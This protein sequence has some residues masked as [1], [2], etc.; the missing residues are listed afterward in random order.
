[1]NPD[2]RTLKDG[3]IAAASSSYYETLRPLD[4]SV[5]PVASST[6]P[7]STLRQTDSASVRVLNVAP[8]ALLEI[9]LPADHLELFV[10]ALTPARLAYPISQGDA[11]GEYRS[12]RACTQR[13][14]CI[15]SV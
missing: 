1:M 7:S 2:G 3:G 15:G 5:G 13:G 8:A 9:P 6:W 4:E 14:G 12:R 11:H 10:A